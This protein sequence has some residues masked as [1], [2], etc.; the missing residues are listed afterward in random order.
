VFTSLRLSGRMP[1]AARL[2]VPLIGVVALLIVTTSAI[3]AATKTPNPGPFTGCLA[4]STNWGSLTVKGQLYNVA[5][6]STT[7]SAP[8]RS[9]D[10]LVTFS[11]SQGPVGPQG[12]QGGQGPKGDTGATGSTGPQGPQGDLGPAGTQGPQGGQGPKGDT[13]AQGPAGPTQTFYIDDAS[14][15]SVGIPAGDDSECRSRLSDAQKWIYARRPDGRRLGAR[16][17]WPSLLRQCFA[18]WDVVDCRGP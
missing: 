10:T 14:S 12:P 5:N 2:S 9:G 11:N 6:S 15:A 13:G 7:P 1:A 4:T 18:Y 17:A 16:S 3:I 8:C